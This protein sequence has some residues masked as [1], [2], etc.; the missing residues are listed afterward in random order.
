MHFSISLGTLGCALSFALG[1]SSEEN[2]R[3]DQPSFNLYQGSDSQDS[4]YN[5]PASNLQYTLSSGNP[6]PNPFM[7]DRLGTTGPVLLQGVNL[8]E[9]LAHF[10]RE[11]VPERTVHAK[12][13]GAHGYF[14]VT[15][16]VGAK[17]SRA[18]LFSEIGKRTSV[19]GRFSTIAGNLGQP[20]SVRDLR[21]LGFKLRT[22]EGILDWVF[23]NHP[24]FWIRDPTKF[25]HFIRSQKRNPQTHLTDY[26]NFWDFLSNNNETIYQVM[27]T[28]SDLGTPYGFR[29]MN[30]HAGNTFRLVK[31]DN[32]WNYVKISAY[33]D[34]GIKNNTQDE[35]VRVAGENSDFGISDLFEAIEAGNYPSW[36]IYFQV[37]DPKTA[38][39]FK[40]NIFD[41]T[42]EWLVEDVPLQEVGR[43]TFN[44]NPTNYF[45]EIEQIGFDPAQMPP[46]IEPTEDP[47]LQA[48]L[49][50]YGDAQ[51]YRIGINHKQLPINA[52]INPVANFLRDGFMSFNNQG[53]RPNYMS[54]IDP[55]N[56][57]QR[58]YNDDNHTIWTGG[59]VKYVSR[60]TELDFELPRIFWNQLSETDQ[61]HL[62]SNV[63]GH[64]GRA[65]NERIKRKQCEIFAHVNA[66][67]GQR[68]A[69]GVNVTLS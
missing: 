56:L 18:D 52:P 40:Y 66:T 25:P 47:M 26:N 28:M 46:G 7:F 17:Y 23:L 50:A 68:I 6:Y 51:R 14:E 16:D 49:F 48:R 19:T 5:D 32:T 21:G 22:N 15:T 35:A 67:L 37:M 54:T 39:K 9:E 13:A 61:E 44:Q 58:P 63:V 10:V 1:V 34:Q 55:I 4:V 31:D 43:I 8:I 33:T 45:A 69:S 12:G 11:R 62:I 41:L 60:P 53:S 27:R 64:L 38:E 29:H 2:K 3:N 57:E 30:G 42:K 24:V 65:T 20:D 59:A 36:T